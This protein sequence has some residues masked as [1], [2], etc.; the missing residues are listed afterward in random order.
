LGGVINARYRGARVIGV[1]A[2]PWRTQ[3]ARELGA[4]AVIDPGDE[5]AL[6]QILA[7]TRSGRGV[8]KAVDCSGAVAAHRLCIDATRRRGQI[9]FVGESSADTPLRVSPDMIRKGLTL[10]GS[11]HYNLAET[12]RMMSMIADLGAEL[13]NLISHTFPIDQIQ[14]AWDTQVS[15][16]CA[17]VI[18]KPW[19]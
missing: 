19:A 7:L 18:L 14:A 16:Q 13:D 12:P 9:A 15:G 6:A 10:V 8:D 3:R 4:E 11:W 5:D 17:K 1:D 2:N